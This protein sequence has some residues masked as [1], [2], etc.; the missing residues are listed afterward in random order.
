[1]MN[2]SFARGVVLTVLLVSAFLSA[3]TAALITLP[4]EGPS[5]P[6]VR[7]PVGQQPTPGGYAVF[8]PSIIG[9]GE[10][11]ALP[12][13]T[14]PV[15]ELTAEEQELAEFLLTDPGQQRANLTCNPILTQVARERAADL[16]QRNYF[17]HVNP[18]GYGPNYL[19]KQAGYALPDWYFQEPEA[20]NI[21]SLAGGFGNAQLAWDALLA[22]ESHRVHV[23]GEDSFFLDQIEYGIGFAFVENSQYQYYWVIL[24]AQH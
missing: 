6:G 17:D 7:A 3:G 5:A 20:N 21:E 2:H 19:V 24:T 12:P 18:D 4:A 14:D 22:S 9:S 23:L 16:G 15:C 1:M 8:L 11:L 13:E 10:E